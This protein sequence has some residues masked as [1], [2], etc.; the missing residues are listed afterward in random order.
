MW[1]ERE[2][3]RESDRRRHQKGIKEKD[4]SCGKW[5]DAFDEENMQEA[6]LIFIKHE[7]SSY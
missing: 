3:E 1:P 6:A 2:R 5:K 7:R 4:N